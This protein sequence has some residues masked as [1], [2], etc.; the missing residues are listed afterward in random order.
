MTQS[1]FLAF[2]PQFSSFTPAVVLQEYVSQ[3]NG[4]FSDWEEPDAEEARRLYVAHKLTLYSFTVPDASG[5]P[6]AA[7]IAAAGKAVAGKQ[8]VASK[9]VGEVSVSYTTGS[10][11][12]SS[13]ESAL[14]DLTETA[15]GLQLLG[16]IRMYSRSRYIP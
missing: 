10:Y 14:A 3:A 8:Q 9:K 4:R 6:S 15:Y 11:L 2:Y 13:A 12:S 16:M 5:T 7:D 1:D